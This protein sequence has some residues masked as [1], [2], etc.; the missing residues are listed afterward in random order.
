MKKFLLISIFFWVNQLQSQEWAILR[1]YNDD[2]KIDNK[3]GVVISFNGI[4]RYTS[5]E[6]PIIGKD[7]KYGAKTYSMNIPNFIKEMEQKGWIL[8]STDVAQFGGMKAQSI[9]YFRKD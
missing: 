9:L 5:A 4:L 6:P 1:Y 2:V 3:S 8:K 7:A